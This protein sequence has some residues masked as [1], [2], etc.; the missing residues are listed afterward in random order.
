M[1]MKNPY[2]NAPK[3]GR[4]IW[5]PQAYSGGLTALIAKLAGW[6]LMLANFD[7]QNRCIPG[8]HAYWRT[9]QSS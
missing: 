7:P 3:V 2:W 6:G 5:Y 9:S 4:S 8:V 1:G